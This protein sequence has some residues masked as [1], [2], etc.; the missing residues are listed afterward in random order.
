M[1]RQ[2]TIDDFPAIQYIRSK[3]G[4]QRDLVHVLEYRERVEKQGFLLY[5]T[6]SSEEYIEEVKKLFL[7]FV[8]GERVKGFITIDNK[9]AINN[10]SPVFWENLQ[11]K[12]LYFSRPHAYLS[13]IAVDPEYAKQGIAT[14]LLKEALMRLSKD[15]AYLFSIVVVSPLNNTPSIMF[16]EKNDFKRVASI[17]YSRRAELDNYQSIVYAKRL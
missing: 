9:Q 1:I 7:V 12:E 17:Q 8:E 2:A 11:M 3:V 4:L 13:G 6:I 14:Q 16:H 5:P 10:D 15:V